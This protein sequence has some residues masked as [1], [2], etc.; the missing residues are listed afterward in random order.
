MVESEYKG[1]RYRFSSIGLAP[2]VPAMTTVKEKEAIPWNWKCQTLRFQ[3]RLLSFVRS[4]LSDK[5]HL[6]MDDGKVE[7]L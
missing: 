3:G 6:P 1:E 2:S 5:L 7:P 4:Q